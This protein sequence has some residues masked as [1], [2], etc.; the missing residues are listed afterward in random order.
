[1]RELR[2]KKSSKTIH[3]CS[4][5]KVH[6]NPLETYGAGFGHVSRAEPKGIG[7]HNSAFP[8]LS[9]VNGVPLQLLPDHVVN[10]QPVKGGIWMASPPIKKQLLASPGASDK[11]ISVSAVHCEPG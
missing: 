9:V 10:V 7:T 1:M 6:R 4:I 11:G 3:E 8:T 5:D 2:T